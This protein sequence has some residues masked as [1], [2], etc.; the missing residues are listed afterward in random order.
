MESQEKRWE[1]PA[2][3]REEGFSSLGVQRERGVLW[4]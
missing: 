4:V 1:N 2:G 3:T